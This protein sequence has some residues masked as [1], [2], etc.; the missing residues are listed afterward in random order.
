MNQPTTWIAIAGGGAIGAALRHGVSLLSL[1][2]MGPA[3]PWGTLTVN[4]VGCAAMGFL[5]AW[6]AGREP[7]PMA[8]RAFLAVGLLGGFTTFSAF[9]LDLVTLYRERA[10]APA[11]I[12]LLA[13][14]ILSVVGLLAGLALGRAVL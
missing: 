14:I 7:N 9:A 12:Y 13:S 10:F 3:F 1:R 8:L 2:L 11:A 4:V 5:V 6:L